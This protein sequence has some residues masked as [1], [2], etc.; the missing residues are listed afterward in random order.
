M[1]ATTLIPLVA[2]VT[3]RTQVSTSL[4]WLANPIFG[5]PPGQWGMPISLFRL[6]RYTNTA[7]IPIIF[8]LDISAV[9]VNCVHDLKTI[10]FVFYDS[11]WIY[12]LYHSYA[13]N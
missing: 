5:P 4:Y 12:D 7:S 9:L 6:F 8:I 3:L 11:L 13:S 1:S 2:I 10:L